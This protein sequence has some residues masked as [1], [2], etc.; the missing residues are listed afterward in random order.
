[1]GTVETGGSRFSQATACLTLDQLLN[2]FPAPSVL[3]ID[4]ESHE[5]SVLKGATK[6]LN[7]IRPA[8][9]CE[10]LDENSAQVTSLLHSAGYQLYGAA[11][12]PHPRIERAW[13]H[14]L[15]IHRSSEVSHSAT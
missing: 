6:L 7:D 15:A 9:W 4:V 14:T 13:H 3:K 11:V 10:V 12:Q 5:A 2:Y 1:M 8:I